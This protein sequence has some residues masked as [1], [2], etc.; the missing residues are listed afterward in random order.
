MYVCKVALNELKTYVKA[1][2]NP[3]QTTVSKATGQPDTQANDLKE[4]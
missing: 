3:G 1:S 4:I 2:T